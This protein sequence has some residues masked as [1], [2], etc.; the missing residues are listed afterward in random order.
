MVVMVKS[1]GGVLYLLL[2]FIICVLVIGVFSFNPASVVVSPI[3]NVSGSLVSITEGHHQVNIGKHY[4]YRDY[5]LIPKYG[6]QSF[7]LVTPIN[8]TAHIVFGVESTNST[9]V[10]KLFEDCVVNSS[11]NVEPVRNRNRLFADDNQV[12]LFV[13]PSIWN[14]SVEIGSGIYG[15][16]RNSAG[17]GARNSAGGG[18][19]DIEEIVLKNSTNY[20]FEVVEQNISSTNVNIFFDWYE[21][22]V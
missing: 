2:A 5:Y 18:A 21:E 13:N 17:G 12:D 11:G 7:L 16:G 10:V 6:N 4:N 20:C 19:R 3:D 14:A 8:Y 22:V 1:E 9:V 15:A